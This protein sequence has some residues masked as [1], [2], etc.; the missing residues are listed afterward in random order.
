[1]AYVAV[2]RAKH[3]LIASA[4]W[5]GPEQVKKRGP[6]PYL[7]TI[8]RFCDDGN[9]VV[10]AWAPQPVEDRNPQ[11]EASAE[12]AWPAQLDQ[13][14]VLARRQAADWVRGYLTGTQTPSPAKLARAERALVEDWD[15]DLAVL[16]E[17]ARRD[18]QVLTDVPVPR[19]LSASALVKLARDPDGYARDIARPMPR[20]P[21][22]AARRG[23]RFHAWVESLFGARPLIDRDELEGAADDEIVD[24][25]ALAALKEAFLDGP[26]A[27]RAPHRVEEPFQIT[28]GGRLIRGRIDAVYRTDTGFEVV[29]WKT[30]S[31]AADHLQLAI[32]RL[33]WARS[34]GIPES[35]VGGAFYYVA[36]GRIDRPR[37]LRDA[38]EIESI[39]TGSDRLRL[40]DGR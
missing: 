33:A 2:T 23:T 14:A 19:S 37:R 17:E 32:Y 22:P 28:L 27:S 40:P 8:R 30:G 18:H 25:N 12:L 4:H 39:L 11:V 31:T 26:Y 13:A 1:L 6:S 24:E 29:D 16:V 20:P 36:T 38:A 15:R 5:W 21:V 34:T 10:G 9:G 7:E 3:R 35:A